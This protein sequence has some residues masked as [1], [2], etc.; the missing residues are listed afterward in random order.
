[1]AI[2]QISVVDQMHE[3]ITGWGETQDSRAIFLSCYAMMTQNMLI[4][5]DND[6]FHDCEW[7]N[8]LLHRFADYYFDALNAYDDH[9]ETTAVWQLTFDAAQRPR[10]HV[11]QHLLLGV[12]A[13]INY[14]LVFTIFDMLNEHWV[15]L[16]PEDIQRRYQ[17]HCH[18]NEV[19]YRTIDA[20]QDD[21]VERHSSAMDIIDKV[22]LTLDE[23]L[24]YRLIC[25][26]RE[27]VWQDATQLMQCTE[28]EAPDVRRLVEYRAVQRGEAILLKHGIFGLRRVF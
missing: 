10:T 1:M 7:V 23:W 3:I 5:I 24:L 21:V 14:D 26:W 11:L 15:N 25:G 28:L 27:Q 18:V 9:N 8:T 20:V 17:D 22:F 2:E 4:A 12:N 19:I 16:S 13:H 6:E